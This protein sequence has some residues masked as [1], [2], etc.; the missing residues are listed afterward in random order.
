MRVRRL[1]GGQTLRWV[2][3]SS[4]MVVWLGAAHAQSPADSVTMTF[5]AYQAAGQNVFVPG[6]F[7]GWGPN[8]SGVISPGAPSQMTYNGTLAA[9]VKTYQFK[10]HSPGD[11]NRTLGDSVYQ[12]KFNS[13]GCSSCWYSDPLNPEVNTLDNN[14]SILRLTKLFWF[15]YY[16][17]LTG[18][19]ITRITAGLVHANSDSI[20]VISLSTGV[21]EQSPLTTVDITGSYDRALRVV[22]YTLASPVAKLAFVRLVAYNNLGD[23]VVYK[24]GGIVVAS[25][26]LPPYAKHGVTLPSTASG[27]SVTFRLRVPGRSYVMLRVAPAGQNPALATPITMRDGG[28]GNWWMNVKLA[29]GQ[30]EYLYEMETG[31]KIYDPWGRWNGTLGSRFVVGPAGLTADDYVWTSNSYVRLPLNKTVIYEMQLAEV[32]GGFLGLGS[33]EGTFDHLKSLLTYFDTLGVT[34]IELM[35]VTDYGSIGASGFSWGYDVSSAFALEPGYG[36]PRDFK[37]LVDS[38][39][40]LGMAIILDVVYNHMTDSAPLWQ[41][42]P[43]EVANPYFKPGNQLNYNEDGLLFFRDMDHW[44]AETQELVYT[45]LK[46][47]IDEYRVDGFRYDYTQGVGWNI[48]T[49]NV[50]ILG[51]ANRID[52]DYGGS[53][54][55]IAEHLPESPALMYYSGLTSG[56]HDSFHDELFNESY[57]F[58]SSLDNIQNIVLGL[59]AYGG[60]DTPSSPSAYANRTEPVNMTVNH[61]EQSLIYEMSVWSPYVYPDSITL[62][63]DKLYGSLMFTSLGIPML[64][65]GVEFS[66]PRG[67]VDGGERLS[68]RPLE[69]EYLSQQR[70]QSHY[71]WYRTLIRQRLKNPALTDGAMRILKQYPSAKTLA[72][73][74]EDAASGAKV[75]IVA[76]FLW[77]DATLTDLPW[78]GQGTWYDVFDQ[79]TMVVTDTILA[80]YSIPAFTARIYSNKSDV[81]LGIVTSVRTP[82]PE[83]PVAFALEQNYP[84]PFNPSTTIRFSLPADGAIRLEVFNLLG[85]RIAVL[86]EGFKTRGLYTATWNGL[87]SSGSP[88]GSGV[89]I[90]RLQMQGM[91]QSRK[92]VLL[93]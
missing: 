31:A 5:R 62:R 70:G 1:F 73:G 78:M 10:I 67:W 49:P 75:M 44:S 40:A 13:G 89:Y 30:Y 71:D 16:S 54:Y 86:D 38:A 59:G 48:A 34:A 61:D 26:P 15:E 8:A 50:G 82:A 72:W 7:N 68:Y 88:A 46:M 4:V 36:T 19:Q 92:I 6:Q 24:T 80:T 3:I 60:N 22:D 90:V 47:W 45:A 63:R 35:P 53:V 37:E 57:N 39:H 12:Y 32:T 23:S 29:A 33:G 77:N 76:N 56:W 85:E 28:G 27:D 74:F 64:W 91:S 20:T 17:F 52:Q 51:W 81:E 41:M 93:R 21:S 2:G 18:D 58:A 55:Q 87:T 69:V 83:L 79:S 14:N 66:A 25:M 65:E 43:D 42:L 9:Y 84:N 11:P